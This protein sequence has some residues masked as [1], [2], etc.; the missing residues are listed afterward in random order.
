MT[1][2]LNHQ[3]PL[4]KAPEEVKSRPASFAAA[5]AGAGSG[6]AAAPKSLLA[7]PSPKASVPKAASSASCWLSEPRPEELPSAEEIK[8]STPAA[9]PAA[10][11]KPRAW[12]EVV[13][14]WAKSIREAD[15]DKV[16]ST[17][18]AEAPEFVP[19]VWM[20]NE[21]QSRRKIRSK[22][23]GAISYDPAA[24]ATDMLTTVVVS[25]VPSET[26]AKG[27]VEQLD[28]W[29]LGGCWDFFHLPWDREHGQNNG[30]AFID[31]IDPVFVMLFCWIYQECQLPGTV[32]MAELQG[33]EA[34][35]FHWCKE[36]SAAEA[37]QPTLLPNAMPTQWAVNTVNGMLSPQFKGQFRK[38]KMCAFNKKNRCELGPRCPFA[39]SKEELQP[40]PDLMKTKLCYMYFRRRC[41]DK[42]CKFAH[43]SAELRSEWMPV[44]SAEVSY[45]PGMWQ[46]AMEQVAEWNPIGEGLLQWR[47]S[48]DLQ[49]LFHGG[50][51]AMMA[52]YPF[53]MQVSNSSENSGGQLDCSQ[54]DRKRGEG[55]LEDKDL[56]PMKA[57]AVNFNSSLPSGRVALR[58]R[59]TFMEAMEA[60]DAEE[61]AC[62]LG[63]PSKRAWSD[64]NLAAL[65][66]AMEQAME[67]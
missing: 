31:F 66:E 1:E 8:K 46:P 42:H 22:P 49:G 33:Y 56:E 58:V 12:A 48:E 61:T 57:A 29:G 65:K 63:L 50:D 26:T 16:Q 44:Q 18:E 43:G 6:G 53:M 52:D 55:H 19:G 38:T 30:F 5:V 11:A 32:T 24:M 40:V 25:G 9:T 64:S 7:S 21:E 2:S 15:E 28:Q 10:P 4:V 62:T 34:N 27:F 60:D 20:S 36:A 13:A 14:P 39:H 41:V 59:G 67:I 47:A 45:S 35:K 3:K 37:V 51:I 54:V 17:L 23:G